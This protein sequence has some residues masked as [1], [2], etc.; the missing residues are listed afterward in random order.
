MSSMLAYLAAFGSFNSAPYVLTPP[1]ELPSAYGRLPAT[2]P[3]KN[4]L[5][6]KGKRRRARQIAS[7]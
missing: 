1:A 7:N 6:Q 4:R 3:G 2:E 5:S